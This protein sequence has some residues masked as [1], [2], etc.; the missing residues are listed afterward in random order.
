MPASWQR[1]V[2]SLLCS[3]VILGVHRDT[4]WRPF[5][6]T[7]QESYGSANA[8]GFAAA[9]TAD[10]WPNPLV[11][12]HTSLQRGE[13]VAYNHWPNG[14]FLLLEGCLRLFGRTENAGRWFAIVGCLLAFSL[15]LL[16]LGRN[17]WLL[18]LT[19]PLLLLSA[20]GR[21]AV[22]FLFNDVGLYISIGMLAFIGAHA[23]GRSKDL[24]FRMALV[25]GV[26]LNHLVAPYVAV[27][28][29]L[30]W[31]DRRS[32][33]RLALDLAILA[34]AC[35]VVLL[36]LAA[37]AAAPEFRAG[38][39]DLWGVYTYRTD[40]TFADWYGALNRDLRHSMNLEPVSSHVAAAAWLI[41]VAARQWRVAVLMPSFVL[42]TVLLREYVVSH[43]FTRLPFLFF[44][45]ITL[46]VAITVLL[47]R[48]PAW[49]L[50]PH[51]HAAGQFLVAAFLAVRLAGGLREYRTDPGV[52][53]LRQ[54]LFRMTADAETGPLLQRCNAFRFL[55]PPGGRGAYSIGQ[56][57]FSVN[58]AQRVRQG[59]P[60]EPC[61]V[62]LAA[63][64][65][66]RRPR[67]KERA[68]P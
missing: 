45:L 24:W 57:F 41:V 34:G 2:V 48:L 30:R 31:F 53:A 3:A 46:A 11:A 65:V 7:L 66:T 43:H 49:R 12:R 58:V 25:L 39:S 9:S 61:D 52:Y 42:F 19:L 28:A 23:G 51:L 47:E 38:V 13:V 64:T 59:A 8:L 44:C 55:H 6:D 5:D 33:R 36:S 20:I 4:F 16:S 27:I 56:L 29:A 14:F 54:T 18:F 37:A 40:R 32:W 35:A 67:V 26:F 68:G 22:P 50:R 1:L 17:D 63:E 62:D 15:L 60:L 10:L 21:D